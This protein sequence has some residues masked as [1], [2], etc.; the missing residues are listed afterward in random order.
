MLRSRTS[1]LYRS[2]TMDGL[3]CSS[4][5]AAASRR[6]PAQSTAHTGGT[7]RLKT[8]YR[9]VTRSTRAISSPRGSAGLYAERE[10][11][12]RMTTCL[13]GASEEGGGQRGGGQVG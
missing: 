5:L 9:E 1:S 12:S 13:V 2:P 11:D 3:S 4:L 6:S 8:R 7:D 10:S